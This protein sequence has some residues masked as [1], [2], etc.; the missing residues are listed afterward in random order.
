VVVSLDSVVAAVNKR[1]GDGTLLKGHDLRNHVL[2]RVT[3]GALALDIALGGG[4]PLNCWNSIEGEPSNGKSVIALKTIAA[5]QAVDKNYTALWIA[6][7]PFVT[8]WAIS[9]NVDMDRMIIADTRVMEDAYQIA[10]EML[11]GRHIDA[12]V[13]DSLSALTPTEEDEKAMDEMQVALGARLTGKFMRKSGVAQRRSLTTPDRPCLSL[14]ISQ[15]REKVGVMWGDNRVTP[16]G[17]AKE[18]F[19]MIR[20]EVRRDEFLG[21]DKH[22]VG[23]SLKLRTTKNKTAPPQR[24]ASMDFYWE[25]HE[26][27]AAGSY[28]IGKQV[29]NIALDMDVVDLAGS[30]YKFDGQS[31][32]GKE[33][34]FAAIE[35]DVKLQR[36]LEFEVRR[37]AGLLGITDTIDTDTTKP[38]KRIAKRA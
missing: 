27:H 1:L 35:E 34:F 19:Y 20:C 24:Q 14:I 12:L 9:C 37:R 26:R 31:W 15:W 22:R 7:E 10:I 2:P 21:T 11:D 38:R 36:R 30:V 8:P 29:A 16:Y 17:R 5:N 18:F 23:I 28:D 25:D 32:R 3:S 33:S 6:A 4:W 13:I